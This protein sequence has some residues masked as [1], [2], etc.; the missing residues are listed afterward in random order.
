M[1]STPLLRMSASSGNSG[2]VAS[3]TD[4]PIGILDVM[5]SG[6]SALATAFHQLSSELQGTLE[7]SSTNPDSGTKGRIR[8]TRL[9]QALRPHLPTRY[10]M[11]LG[12]VVINIDGELSTPQDIVI[13]DGLVAPPFM[14]GNE[15]HPIEAVCAVIEVKSGYQKSD[16]VH[17]VEQVA[18]V[19]RLRERTLSSVEDIERWEAGRPDPS[20]FGAVFLY[21]DNK[22]RPDTITRTFL[23]ASLAKPTEERPDALCVLNRFATQW[24]V[25]QQMVP[26]IYSSPHGAKHLLRYDTTEAA[27]F[28]Y[29]HLLEK[30]AT[31][32]PPPLDLLWYMNLA[33]IEFEVAD[34][35]VSG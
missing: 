29:I 13:T 7:S 34:F 27:L 28:F 12:G 20:L 1:S 17:G 33:A 6:L 14:F 30:L 4:S 21:G 19:K 25:D 35:D 24:S 8:E 22:T 9:M 3:E 2:C 5:A 15:I 31:Y 23:D 11:S 18:S 32:R 26:V 10:E 16:L